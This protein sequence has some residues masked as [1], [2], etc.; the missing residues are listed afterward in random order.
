M[1]LIFNFFN[2]PYL[3]IRLFQLF[4]NLYFTNKKFIIQD[5]QKPK[6]CLKVYF[7]SKLLTSG[8]GYGYECRFDNL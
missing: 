5:M 8:S 4:I 3:I 2:Y 7:Y 6:K 1:F